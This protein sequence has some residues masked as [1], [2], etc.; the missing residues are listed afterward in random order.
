MGIYTY[1][2]TRYYLAH[3]YNACGECSVFTVSVILS[4]HKGGEGELWA[5]ALFG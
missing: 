2:N 3:A 5:G 1:E 4:V